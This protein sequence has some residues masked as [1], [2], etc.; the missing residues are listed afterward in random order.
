LLLLLP[1]LF[2][3]LLVTDVGVTA[4]NGALALIKD[5]KVLAA[6]AGIA[7]VEAYHAGTVRKY[8]YSIKDTVLA[9]YTF[10][11]R[12]TAYTTIT[13][14][15]YYHCLVV[16]PNSATTTFALCRCSATAGAS[17]QRLCVLALVRQLYYNTSVAHITSTITA[18]T[19]AI[20]G[21]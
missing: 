8:L 14:L 9:P 16:H 13:R 12:T 2:T 10:T 4:Y 20:T 7:S 6:A 11:V 21:V 17:A 1:L 18:T 19:A 3:V 15:L 5:P